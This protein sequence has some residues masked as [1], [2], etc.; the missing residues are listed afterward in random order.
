M[1]IKLQTLHL[2]V[3]IATLLASFLRSQPAISQV[4]TP[5][6][7]GTGTQVTPEGNHFHIQGGQLSKDGANLFHSF[8]HFGLTPGQIANFLSNP[9]IRNILGRVVG[10]DPSFINGLIQVSGGNSNLFLV[11]PAGILFGLNASLNLPGDFLA[12]TATGIGLGDDQWLNVLGENQWAMLVGEPQHFSFA[13]L[14]PG[15][16]ANLGHLTLQ[17]GSNLTLLGG[18]VLN[19]GTLSVPG[20]TITLA[21]VPGESVV[22]LSQTGHLLTLS[23]EREAFAGTANSS[24]ALPM[25]PL[26]LPELLTGGMASHATGVEVQADGTIALTGSG[27]K[28]TPE[29]GTTIAS[30]TLDVSNHRSEI[31]STQSITLVGDRIA[32][33]DAQLDASGI[34]GG[35]TLRIGGEERGRGAIANATHSFIS[36]ESLITADAL[37]SGNGGRVVI[38]ADDTTAF[39]GTI[40]ARG[41]SHS[42]SNGGTVEVSGKQQLIFRGNI[43]LTAPNGNVGTLLLDPENI[44]IVSGNGGT[45]DHE[46][47]DGT[48][49]F[50]EAGDTFTLSEVALEGISE[51][52]SVIL[53]ATNDITLQPLEDN[54]LDFTP[55]TGG[56]TFKADA[57]GDGIG[58]FSMSEGDTIFTNGRNITI[59]AAEIQ[60]GGINTASDNRNS[61]D[62]NLTAQFDIRLTGGLTANAVGIYNGG[63]ITLTSHAGAVDTQA[64]FLSSWTEEGN[65]GSVTLQGFEN[66]LTGQINAESKGSGIG[67]NITLE[68]ATGTINTQRGDIFSQSNLGDAGDVSFTAYGDITTQ[69]IVSNSDGEGSLGNGGN[70]TLTSIAGAVD[71]TAGFI[72]SWT[73]E[74]NAGLVTL[75]AFG[76]IQTGMIDSKAAGGGNGGNITLTSTA[77]EIIARPTA[78]PTGE[79]PQD[80]GLYSRSV[81]GDSG[82]VSLTAY[83]NIITSNIYADSDGEGSLGNG[84]NIILTSETGA[85]D[86]TTGYLSS[87]GG[88]DAGSVTLQAFGDILTGVIDSKAAGGGNGGNI[89]LTSITG[90]INTAP[91]GAATLE[92]NQGI[93]LYSFSSF[94]NSGQV[95]LTAP[96]NITTGNIWSDSREGTQGNGGNITLTSTTGAIDTRAG[97]L[98]S[99]AGGNAGS[100]TLQAFGPILT[101]IIDSYAQGSGTGGDIT[102]AST[103]GAI[104]TSSAFWFDSSSEQGNA[105]NIIFN[106]PGD[107]SVS[108]IRSFSGGSG[109]GG[110]ITLESYTGKIEI[111]AELDS[112]SA[113]GSGGT[114]RIAALGDILTGYVSSYSGGDA[115]GIG[116]NIEITST[117]GAI[118]TTWGWIGGIRKTREQDQ[119]LTEAA[120]ASTDDVTDPDIANTFADPS[121]IANID[122]YAA[123]GTGGNVTLTAAQGIVTRDISAYGGQNSGSVSLETRSGDIQT[124]VIFSVSEQGNGGNI[125]LNADNGN[126][127]TSHLNT[128]V[129]QGGTGGQ[130]NVTSG[131]TF[132]IGAATI[133]SFSTAGIAG[134]VR[135]NANGDIILGGDRNRSAVRSQGEQQGGNLSI[136]SNT[137]EILSWFGSLDSYSPAGNA[138]NVNLLAQ[139]DI[140]TNGVLSQGQTQGG[141]IN[142][143]STEGVTATNWGPLQ[144]FSEQGIAGDVS[145]V[146]PGAITTGAILSQGLQQGGNITLTSREGL[147]DTSRGELRSLSDQGSAGH[148]SIQSE[149]TLTTG[150]IFSQGDRAGGDINLISNSVNSIEVQGE[151]ETLSNRGMAG[152]VYLYSPGNIRTTSI[153]SQGLMRGGNITITSTEG[154][155]FNRGDLNSYSEQGTAGKIILDASG[156]IST[157]AIASYGWI[158]SGDV[159]LT[160]Q[161][162]GITTGNITTLADN[163]PTGNIIITAPGFAG[164]IFTGNLS[165]IGTAAG[166][167]INTAGGNLVSGDQ[168]ISSSGDNTG[169]IINTVEGD[170]TIGDQTITAGGDNTGSITNTIDGDATI[171][172]QTI[173]AGGD[174]TGSITNTIGGDATI[175]DQTISAG[176]DNTGNITNTIGGDATIGDQTITAGGDNTGS[177]TNTIGGDAT[178]GIQDINAEGDNFGK[179]VNTIEGEGTITAQGTSAGGINLGEIINNAEALTVIQTS[180]TPSQT[181][182][183]NQ[184]TAAKISQ[185]LTAIQGNVIGTSGSQAIALLEQNRTQE[186][187]DYFGRDLSSQAVSP[188]SVRDALSAIARQTGNR[189]AV[190][191]INALADELELLVF[192]PEGEPIRKTVPNLPRQD[193]IDL[194]I[195]FRQILTN[196]RY[197]GSPV[198]L[199]SAQQLYQWLIAPVASEL[200]ALEINTLLFSL[201]EGLRSL[202]LAA[203]HDGEQFLVEHYSLALIPSMGLIDTQYQSLQG[204]RVL[205]MGASEFTE[206]SALPAVPVELEAIAGQLWQGEEFLNE[207]F[208]LENLRTQ[209]SQ[210]PYRIIHLATHAEF[211]PGPLTNSYIQLWNEQL[212][213]EGLRSLGWN[214][215]P[216]ELLVLSACRTAV[217][218]RHA[219]LGFAGL[220]IQSG[221]KSALASLWYVSDEGTLALMTEFY[222]HLGQSTIKAE[223]LR[224]AQIAM[225]RGEVQ[226]EAG[227]L[228]G[229]GT[230][231]SVTLPPLLAKNKTVNLSHPYFWSSFT[232]IGNPW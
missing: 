90:A 121:T 79:Q 26:S 34:T 54:R 173:T 124:G 175:G 1:K 61:G 58:S 17:P 215:L 201:D 2:W 193:V 229:S 217:G 192:T 157:H 198:Y 214:D 212:D 204:S 232:L 185:N 207:Q 171:G 225:L 74:G 87:W 117:T 93:G 15:A 220:A 21:A 213:L 128:Y 4:V 64:N 96:G 14:Q 119:T 154:A 190:I 77:G 10:G 218:D 106:A 223:A 53:E 162:L 51:N 60:V 63:N 35:G 56:L 5:A 16:V 155:I 230:R 172:D 8:Q 141:D 29:T 202:P 177:I 216:V 161:N 40:Q 108:S 150:S 46:I 33:L 75:A 86:T 221:V 219:E 226:I 148:V 136:T 113:T 80:F 22:S 137:G 102:L 27:P 132:N 166:S 181:L 205:A 76:D 209:R 72:T 25:T 140:Y 167:I 65:A 45:Q 144:S 194:A 48:I 176:G 115:S 44:I 197:Q 139:S 107:I 6:H 19:A 135:I 73:E 151:L 43:D 165:A 94:G 37:S 156:E 158:E 120:I 188:A 101:G 134:D 147:I 153:L 159:Q 59:E 111:S 109:R 169:E 164:D 208:T 85:V 62:I 92:E 186:Y 9:E 103:T 126:I 195:Q 105:G 52:A 95:S 91:N 138:G 18:T 32:V 50:G 38:W 178:I 182:E 82:D 31:P 57:D 110:D 189:S 11:N 133:N 179:I 84:G 99:W 127:T 187:E 228:R 199:K 67:G 168:T 231:G 89:T 152:N 88:G 191:Y 118:D 203:L 143:T 69:S 36:G 200:E 28:I 81:L 83:G 206:L 227:E 68:S 7:D 12:T 170:A 163:G 116:G 100:V 130:I 222:S 39:Y 41:G 66:I 183:L 122:A 145:V 180:Q 42:G 114:I 224:E 160:S 123:R 211:Q 104:D 3:I 78:Q 24:H 20:G 97:Y 184:D 49:Q 55:G 149:G 129:N 146:A 70:I 13:G 125:R 71:T 174:N 210:H 30:G 23:I 98:S 142:L 131:G 47:T 112:S 196:P